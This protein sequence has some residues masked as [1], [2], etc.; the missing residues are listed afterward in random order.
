MDQQEQDAVRCVAVDLGAGSGRVIVAEL[1][2]GLIGLTEVHRFTT[3]LGRDAATGHD[4]WDSDLIVAN[5]RE[6]LEKAA[7]I[8]PVM[9]VGCD[10]WGVDFVLLDEKLNKVGLSVAYR[11]GRTAGLMDEVFADMPPAEIY[12]RT[13]IHFQPYNSLYQL[14]ATARQHPDWLERARHLLFTPDYLHFALSGEIC[15][16]YTIATTS[17]LLSLE[18][19]DFDPELLRIAGVT[20]ALMSKPVAPGTIIGEVRLANSDHPIKVIAPGSHDTAS[21]VAAA[22]IGSGR[23]AF[24]SSGTWSLMGI[25]SARAY[26][27]DLARQLNFGNEGGVAGTYRVLKNLM[28]LWLIQRVRKEL[29]DPGFADLVAAAEAAPAWRTLIDPDDNRFLNPP[30]MVEAICAF[31]AERG[32]PAPVGLGAISRCIFDSL[33]LDYAHVK[34]ELEQLTG[35]PIDT[36]R[37]IGGGSQNALLNQLTADAC[38]VTVTAGPI[39]TSALGNACLQM[40]A[41]GAISSLAEARAIVSR[42]FPL[43]AYTPKNAVPESVRSRFAELKKAAVSA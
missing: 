7:A 33:A 36:I 25:E 4:V 26:T 22:P 2:D 24:V 13:G 5:V 16:E 9:S 28:G 34:G 10:T 11:D 42:S 19:G 3:P 20:R 18:S 15:N 6:G 43:D 29:G 41:L 12:R 38:G 23:E 37:I 8:A 17:Q 35:H 32:E 14:R 30:G 40:I 31:A 39:E 27:S 1:K 21:A